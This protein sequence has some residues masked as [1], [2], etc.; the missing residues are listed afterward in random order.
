M[1]LRRAACP[2]ELVCCCG[3]RRAGKKEKKTRWPAVSGANPRNQ[4]I[5]GLDGLPRAVGCC[6]KSPECMLSSD[7]PRI[8]LG[9]NQGGLA[10]VARRAGVETNT[11]N[12]LQALANCPPTLATR[13]PVRPQARR[14]L[15]RSLGA[16][17][18]GVGR[19]F[20]FVANKNREQ[21]VLRLAREPARRGR[22]VGVRALARLRIW[23]R[24]RMPFPLSNAGWG[25]CPGWADLLAGELSEEPEQRE[26]RQGW[27]RHAAL[28][29]HSV[30]R[31]RDV[32]P[33]MRPRHCSAALAAQP[34]SRR[35]AFR[36]AHRPRR[37][38]DR[39]QLPLTY[40]RCV[41]GTGHGCG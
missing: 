30:Y 13:T 19:A 5:A 35:L 16:G 39:L 4:L 7:S 26:R 34:A 40:R 8:H 32:L 1:G 27:Q 22:R 15:R 6:G 25:S 2:V 17:G 37:S 33:F 21:G 36:L 12:S 3:K 10:G 9:K 23:P 18:V 11:S 31:E 41:D 14:A 38:P 24:G 20:H 28:Y 29:L